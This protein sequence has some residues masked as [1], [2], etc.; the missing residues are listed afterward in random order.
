MY[1]YVGV[2]VCL[3]T[4]LFCFPLPRDMFQDVEKTVNDE[5][6]KPADPNGF[7]L[8]IYVHCLP[9]CFP[10]IWWLV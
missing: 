2:C 9:T 8:S 3:C 10:E 7:A 6:L 5:E 1:I 4:E